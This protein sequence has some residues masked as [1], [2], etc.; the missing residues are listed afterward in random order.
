MKA[1]GPILDAPPNGKEGGHQAHEAAHVS[2]KENTQDSNGPKV[3]YVNA[4][5]L[6]EAFRNKEC[7]N[8]FPIVMSFFRVV[9]SVLAVAPVIIGAS[10]FKDFLDVTL[11]FVG[12]VL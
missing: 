5:L 12:K 3:K 10:G 7:V 4:I 9:L 8:V 11:G 6:I 2:L 1:S